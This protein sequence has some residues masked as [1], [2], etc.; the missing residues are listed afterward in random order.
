M[1][2]INFS[3]SPDKIVPRELFFQ[4]I[5]VLT[6]YDGYIVLKKAD[7][8][9][10]ASRLLKTS[11]DVPISREELVGIHCPLC[12]E[13]QIV[14]MSEWHFQHTQGHG[15][16]CG[17]GKCSPHNYMVLDNYLGKQ[18]EIDEAVKQRIAD[19]IAEL[20]KEKKWAIES[21]TG[22]FLDQDMYRDG[23]IKTCTKTIALLRGDGK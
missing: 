9:S 14:P 6:R 2:K 20:E 22:Q 7:G 23:I 5:G 3:K 16:T 21:T 12:G 18:V 15:H 4:I 17:S 13:H 10:W 8:M 11:K 19:V 1:A